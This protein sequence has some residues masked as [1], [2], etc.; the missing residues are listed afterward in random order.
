MIN[1][2]AWKRKEVGLT[3]DELMKACGFTNNSL[4]RRNSEYVASYQAKLI[5]SSTLTIT[6][7]FTESWEVRI[8]F[9]ELGFSNWDRI[10][11]EYEISDKYGQDVVYTDMYRGEGDK[12]YI[13]YN[14][15]ILRRRKRK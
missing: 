15:R 14:I 8:D 13:I 11:F 7:W 1:N 10:G 5:S 9:T 12:V 2:N 6:G 4:A 3:I